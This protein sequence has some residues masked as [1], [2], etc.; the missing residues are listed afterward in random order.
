MEWTEV[1]TPDTWKPEKEGDSIE[2][3][4]IQKKKNVGPNESMLYR[5]KIDDN[6]MISIWGSTILDNLLE[7]VEEGTKVKITFK[8]T[9]KNQKGQDVKI[10]KVEQ[11]K[12]FEPK[13]TEETVE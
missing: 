8:T 4:L 11:Q 12:K 13:V 7:L 5:L 1:T 2:G 9:E 3:E 6:T 10:W